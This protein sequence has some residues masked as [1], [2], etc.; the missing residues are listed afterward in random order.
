MKIIIKLLS[1]AKCDSHLRWYK[2]KHIHRL[3]V[4]KLNLCCAGKRLYWYKD[5]NIESMAVNGS[6]RRV[7]LHTPNMIPHGITLLGENLYY[8]DNRYCPC[9]LLIM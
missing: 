3:E 2:V 8:T 9:K 5:E 1:Y 6:D 7:F 4:M